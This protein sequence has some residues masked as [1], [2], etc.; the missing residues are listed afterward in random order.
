MRTIPFRTILGAGIGANI[1]L[2]GAGCARIVLSTGVASMVLTAQP[3]RA[4][5]PQVTR[6]TGAP[7]TG[8]DLAGAL[9]Y[10]STHAD[11]AAARRADGASA[12]PAVQWP[13]KAKPP[14]KNFDWSGWY[15]GAHVG[16]TTGSSKWSTMQAGGGAPNL[17]GSFD[18][19]FKFDFMTGTRSL[20]PGLGGGYKLVGRA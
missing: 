2:A 16:V 5:D 10:V 3:A 9:S 1:S 17:S 19:P 18:F 14:V 7:A 13:T 20:G 11:S 12:N 15:A 4:A 8:D 6:P